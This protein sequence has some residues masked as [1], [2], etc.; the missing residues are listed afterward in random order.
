MKT[1][2]AHCNT[3]AHINCN[4]L[5]YTCTLT[6]QHT[7]THMQLT[8][9]H[10]ATHLHTH[11]AHCNTPANSLCNTLQHTCILTLQH[12]AAHLHTHTATHCNTPA[13]SLCNTPAHLHCNTLQHTCTLTL[14]VRHSQMMSV[15]SFPVCCSVLQCVAVCRS[16]LQR[17]LSHTHHLRA[18]LANRRLCRRRKFLNLNRRAC[19]ASQFPHAKF[20]FTTTRTACA[21]AW[22]VL[23]ACC[24]RAPSSQSWSICFASRTQQAV[25][26]SSTT[27]FVRIQLL[28]D[29][30]TR[31]ATCTRTCCSVCCSVC[32]SLQH[33][34]CHSYTNLL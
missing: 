13:H 18:R 34:T 32:L 2:K 26:F 3:S 1:K 8:L 28:H 5:Q 7:A 10:I 22:R 17:A 27:V 29:L 23:H 19:H 33:V 9:Q 15:L 11:T 30:S 20:N 16:A 31:P 21:S 12:T 14:P 25:N 6:R 24:S 4:R